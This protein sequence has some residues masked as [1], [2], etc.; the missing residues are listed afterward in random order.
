MLLSTN[1]AAPPTFS[2]SE[3]GLTHTSIATYDSHEQLEA[4]LAEMAEVLP[5]FFEDRD[6][7]C[8]GNNIVVNRVII[9]S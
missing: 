1:Y 2:I 6:A 7:Y 4:F 8:V 3:D 9:T 5:T